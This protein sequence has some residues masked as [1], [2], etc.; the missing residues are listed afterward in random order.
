[1][2]I[3]ILGG[4]GMIGHK[5]YQIL[6]KK[7]LDTWVLFK[8]KIENINRIEIY[9]NEKIIDNF[10]L[11]E[12]E[13]LQILLNNLYPDFIINAAGITIR[14]GINNN[15]HRTILINSALPHLLAEWTKINNKKLIHFSTDCVFSGKR[16]FYSELSLPDAE[17]LYGKT[18]ALGEVNNSNTLTLRGSMIGRELEN[19]TELL[20]WFLKQNESKLYGFSKVI[21]S[22]IT[23]N[24]MAEYIF[25]IINY[26]PDM[27]GIYNVSST[28]IS[29]YDLLRLFNINFKKT[30]NIISDK[31][32]ESN[33]DLDSFKFYS[34]TKFEK[35]NWTDLIKELY[36]DSV[37][38]KNI[39]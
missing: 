8:K 13:K 4:N 3:L 10:D 30:T 16:G 24:R 36:I 20:E 19:K 2:R 9:N 5:I 11:I 1:M 18:K 39:Y 21:Y 29:K 7:H 28:P 31:S 14:R 6:S 35:P 32:Y 15:I 26:Y 12:F 33:K 23:T 25:R 38:N 17:D 22:G 34:E 37:L 27:H